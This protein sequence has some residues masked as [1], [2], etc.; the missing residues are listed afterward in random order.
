MW[1]DTPPTAKALGCYMASDAKQTNG[2]TDDN[3]ARLVSGRPLDSVARVGGRVDLRGLVV[4]QPRVTRTLRVGGT[5]VA[6]LAHVVV[7]SRVHWKGMDFSG[8]RLP[9]LRFEGC[10]IEDCVFDDCRCDDWRMWATKVSNCSFKSAHLKGAALGGV[11]LDGAR[12]RFESVNFSRADL[13]D[14]CYQS[15]DFVECSFRNAKLTKVDFQGSVFTRCVFEG[16]LDQV[17]FYRHAF[18]GEEFPPNEMRDVDFRRATFRHVE[19]RALDM[20][21]V[22]WPESPDHILIEDYRS[23]L[24]QMLARLRNDA[25][26]HSGYVRTLLAFKLRWAGPHQ[27]T[28]VV[29]AL[30]LAT[31]EEWQ[32]FLELYREVSGGSV[33]GRSG[34]SR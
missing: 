23:V 7:M 15:A 29:S 26:L 19:F 3:W 30:D 9:S 8:A 6:E 18:Q 4:P 13:R 17:L 1:R 22:L 24:T 25:D 20:E 27:V 12:N 11:A 28:G 2:N 21:N 31:P 16:L 5:N 34:G 32:R 33:S 14:T 10:T